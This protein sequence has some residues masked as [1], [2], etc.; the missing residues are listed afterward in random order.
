MTH[1]TRFYITRRQNKT[2]TWPAIYE[3][4][5]QLREQP[6]KGQR[7]TWEHISPIESRVARQRDDDLRRAVNMDLAKHR[8]HDSHQPSPG[9]QVLGG[10][11]RKLRKGVVR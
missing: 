4:L 2:F 8:V 7:E 10:L 5:I 11:G 3:P 6:Q 1:L 9:F